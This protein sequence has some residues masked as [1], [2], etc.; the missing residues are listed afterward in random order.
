[1]VDVVSEIEI[2]RPRAEVAAYA[3]DPD[4]ARSWYQN[5]KDVE[6]RS[7]PPLDV[8]SRVAFVA[9]FLGRRL[10]YAYDWILEDRRAAHA[11]RGPSREPQG[12]RSP[13]ARARERPPLGAQPAL[14]RISRR[15]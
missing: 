7:T 8:G 10:E 9:E 12:P 2:D 14:A 4:N 3:S 5:I 11:A 15:S 13:Q 6:W 1:V